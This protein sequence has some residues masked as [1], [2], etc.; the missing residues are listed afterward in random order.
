MIKCL[1]LYLMEVEKL[2]TVVGTS[3]DSKYDSNDL[4]CVG[5]HSGKPEER[6]LRHRKYDFKER[7]LWPNR[8]RMIHSP[9]YG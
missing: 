1:L 6:V 2:G 7:A 9:H 4:K 3:S 5:A 8:S